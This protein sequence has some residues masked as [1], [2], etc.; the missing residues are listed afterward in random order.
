M[1]DTDQATSY[2]VSFIY[3]GEMGLERYEEITVGAKSEDEAFEKAKAH[4]R[5]PDEFERYTVS[6]VSS[7][8]DG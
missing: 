5:A 2:A 3:I 1:T 7:G 8:G 4:S 6:K